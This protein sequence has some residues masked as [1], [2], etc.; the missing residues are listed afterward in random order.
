VCKD[1]SIEHS[2]QIYIFDSNNNH[3]RELILFFIIIIGW[4]Y[5]GIKNFYP[6]Q[7]NKQ[8]PKSRLIAT[9][10]YNKGSG[11]EKRGKK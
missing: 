8:K 10:A 11:T 4:A 5:S 7:V 3:D 2:L 9:D 6:R 1:G